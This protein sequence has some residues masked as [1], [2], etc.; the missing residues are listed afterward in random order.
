MD[1]NAKLARNVKPLM[2][3]R[4]DAWKCVRCGLC[5]MV[6]AQT[7]V[8]QEYV[9]NCPAGILN[10]FELFYPAG[11]QELIRCLTAEPPEIDIDDLSDETLNAIFTCTGCGNCQLICN[12]M[13]G[14]E[15]TNAFQ[16]L[17][18]WAIERYGLKKEHHN[19]IQSILNYDNPWMAPRSTRSRWTRKLDFNIKDASKEK[20]DILYFPG[21]NASYVPEINLTA[22]AT[23]KVL[24]SAG[25]DFGM[26]GQK[27]RCCGST[28]FRIGAV[29]MFEAYKEENIKQLNSLGIKTM[30]TACAGCHSTFSHNYAGRLDFEVVH[31]V[32]YL[33]RMIADGQ[34]EFKNDLNLKVTYHD[35]CHIGRYSSI[36]DAPRKVLE[37]L[38]GVQFKEMK[39]IREN[40]L[41][42]GSGG[43]VKTAYGDMALTM[44]GQRLDEARDF[45]DADVVVSCCPFCEI[46]LG[47]AAKARD[48]GMK[49]LDLLELVDDA[50]R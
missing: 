31:V 9:D 44:A 13:K 42:C 50:M 34:I 17:K 19:L 33:E 45:A 7:I 12:E 25:I 32:E 2:E 30:V 38:P 6:D 3:Y 18:A 36:Y 1:Y 8:D 23:A 28:A 35:P 40:S 20:V 16:A 37:A 49:V 24:H 22:L 21:C 43:G 15:P 47:E 26:L 4:N 41:C 46:N 29:E 39:R 14:L 27:E 10:K 5:R 48:D 11:R